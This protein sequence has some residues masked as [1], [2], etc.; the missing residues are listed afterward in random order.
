MNQPTFMVT[1]AGLLT[2][3]VNN[4]RYTGTKRIVPSES[5]TLNAFGKRE[6]APGGSGAPPRNTF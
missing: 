6:G 3:L 1:N 5:A 2:T 4:S